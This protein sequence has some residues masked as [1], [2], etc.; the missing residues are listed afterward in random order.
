MFYAQNQAL[1]TIQAA[2]GLEG[3]CPLCREPVFSR[4][5]TIHRWHFSHHHHRD[6]DP[7]HEYESDWHFQW[8][9][10]VPLHMR[11]VVIRR[12][13][14]DETSGIPRTYIESHRAD[15]LNSRQMVIELQ[16]SH[17][18][19][20]E[21]LIRE[22]F[23]VNMIWLWDGIKYAPQFSTQRVGDDLEFTWKK[24]DAKIFTFS[25]L[26]KP[27]FIDFGGRDSIFQVRSTFDLRNRTSRQTRGW[28]RGTGR[29][30]DKKTF[31]EMFFV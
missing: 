14:H 23:Y 4:C 12:E 17:L 31:K 9:S 19:P 21:A 13:V 8:K 25:H 30:I 1:E 16:H 28:F 27:I 6:C 18:K 2:P 26:R 5:G 11:E 20:V 24:A 15:I 7:W 29:Y 3:F 22:D 10:L